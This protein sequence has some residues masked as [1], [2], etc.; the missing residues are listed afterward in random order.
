MSALQDNLGSAISVP[1]NT[2]DGMLIKAF[3]AWDGTKLNFPKE[4]NSIDRLERVLWLVAGGF[5]R[6]PVDSR[7]HVEK[8][9]QRARE[10]QRESQS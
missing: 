10:I 2:L 4:A 3:S 8:T 1:V 9:L 6:L 7:L 5:L